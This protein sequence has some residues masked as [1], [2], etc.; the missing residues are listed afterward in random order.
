MCVLLCPMISL[1]FFCLNSYLRCNALKFASFLK[2]NC[3]WAKMLLDFFFFLIPVHMAISAKC[4]SPRCG[5]LH[6]KSLHAFITWLKRSDPQILKL[7]LWY[8]NV[9]IQVIFFSRYRLLLAGLCPW[10][11]NR[12]LIKCWNSQWGF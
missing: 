8:L 2:W 9:C 5:Y 12:L 10:Q 11:T 7:V 3:C 4:V 1:V 6:L